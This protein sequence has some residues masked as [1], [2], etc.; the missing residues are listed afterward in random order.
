MSIKHY[1]SKDEDQRARFIFNMIAPYYHFIDR[2]TK[3]DYRKMADILNADTPLEGKSVLDLGCGTGSWLK[4]LSKY[5]LQ[6]ATGID[7]SLSMLREAKKQNPDL[8]CQQH[9]GEVTK[10]NDNTFD[11]VTATFVLHGMKE[12][13]RLILLKEMRRVARE[14]VIIHDFYGKTQLIAVWLEWLERSDF[15]HF[16][17]HF[18]H[19][20]EAVFTKTYLLP[21]IGGKA[22]YIGCID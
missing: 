6:K 13:K 9:E 21:G 5:P 19:E 20:M 14:K 11:I 4:A 8:D 15:R 3:N 18:S 1:F 22:L 17:K 12:Q 16:K 2:G 10:F 7:M